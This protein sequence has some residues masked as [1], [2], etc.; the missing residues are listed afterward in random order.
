M[1]GKIIGKTYVKREKESSR[2][3]IG[4]GSW[5]IKLDE[6]EGKEIDLIRFVTEVAIYEITT[7]EAVLR[8]FERY[9]GGERKLVV[10]VKHWKTA[11]DDDKRGAYPSLKRSEAQDQFEADMEACDHLGLG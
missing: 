10:A 6:I 7:S 2:L 1:I 3:R 11:T 4:G 9:L 8:G 5:T